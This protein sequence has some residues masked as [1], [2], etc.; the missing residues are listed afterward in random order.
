M[1]ALENSP[2]NSHQ[3]KYFR[4]IFHRLPALKLVYN[5]A[6]GNLQTVQSMTREYLF[7]LADRLVHVR[8]SDNDGLT[9]AHLPF[10][11]PAAGGINLQHEL[12]ILRSFR[13]DGSIALEITGERR[14]LTVS[15]EMLHELWPKAQ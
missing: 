12:R 15:G 14:W 8:I 11:A 2:N 4:E 5:I 9:N 1:V 10:G 13:Y 6:H 7:A 3:L